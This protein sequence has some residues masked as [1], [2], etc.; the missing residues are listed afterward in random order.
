[1]SP[2]LTVKVRDI[3]SVLERV[4]ATVKDAVVSLTVKGGGCHQLASKKQ[5]LMTHHL[6][7]TL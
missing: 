2:S 3:V 6:R 4:E 1:M 5:L 7:D